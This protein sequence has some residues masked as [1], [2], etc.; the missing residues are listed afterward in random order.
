MA[1]FDFEGLACMVVIML[2]NI[3]FAAVN[4]DGFSHRYIN[5]WLTLAE[6]L[7][8]YGCLA[9]MLLRVPNLY[10][11]VWYTGGTACLRLIS[12]ALCA[13]YLLCWGIF[14][15]RSGIARALFLSIVPSAL[16]FCRGV[17]TANLPLLGCS[18]L[19]A[20]PHILISCRSA[21][22]D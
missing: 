19:F 2:P 5:K 20:P 10:G 16:F 11:G 21:A 18:L 15:R 8:R 4:P 22:G 13:M 1:W 6:Q 14:W 7:G 17:L 3:L 9:F 12:A